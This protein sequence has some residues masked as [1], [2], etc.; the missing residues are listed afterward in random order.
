MISYRTMH[1]AIDQLYTTARDLIWSRY[2]VL[3]IGL[4]CAAI[5]IPTRGD[6]A[7]MFHGRCVGYGSTPA[8]AIEMIAR[9]I[10]HSGNRRRT[11]GGISNIVHTPHKAHRSASVKKN[12]I[13]SNFARRCKA[14]NKRN[15][16]TSLNIEAA[17]NKMLY[18]ANKGLRITTR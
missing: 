5:Y 10:I 12:P 6:F 7:A 2:A 16:L 13:R 1:K 3:T 11:S 15:A 8:A 18:N 14:L 17:R 4:D 9:Y